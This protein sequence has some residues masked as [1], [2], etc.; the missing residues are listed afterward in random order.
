MQH[1]F[2]SI[3]NI[4]IGISQIRFNIYSALKKK[5]YISTWSDLFTY[6]KMNLTWN[7]RSFIAQFRINIL[8]LHIETG[9]FVVTKPKDRICFICKMEPETEIHFMFKCPL[10]MHLRNHWLQKVINLYPTFSTFPIE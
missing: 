10:Y 9:C 8:P 1:I 5:T 6:V 4:L 7:T 3:H 2:L